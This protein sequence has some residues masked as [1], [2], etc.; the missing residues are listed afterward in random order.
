MVCR[1]SRSFF[2]TVVPLPN[3]KNHVQNWRII[4]FITA[5]DDPQGAKRPLVFPLHN[6]LGRFGVPCSIYVMTSFTTTRIIYGVEASFSTGRPYH[7]HRRA[8]VNGSLI[9]HHSGLWPAEQCCLLLRS[10][11]VYRSL[12]QERSWRLCLVAFLSARM[13]SSSESHLFNCQTRL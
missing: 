10:L 7:A 5:P 13:G 8:A 4:V 3:I 2:C 11:K 1:R 9:I 6:L 12:P